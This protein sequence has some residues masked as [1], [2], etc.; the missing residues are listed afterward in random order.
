MLIPRRVARTMTKTCIA[1]LKGPRRLKHHSSQTIATDFHDRFPP[2]GGLVREILLFQ[3][4]LHL[5]RSFHGSKNEKKA[6]DRAGVEPMKAFFYRHIQ[7][8]KSRP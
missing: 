8:F 7:T 6:I 2:N 3:G 1:D 5:S 4:N